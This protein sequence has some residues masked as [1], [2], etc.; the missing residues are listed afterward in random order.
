M[1]NIAMTFDWLSYGAGILTVPAVILVG[2]L[3]IAGYKW[4]KRGINILSDKVNPP[5]AD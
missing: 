2:I 3:S 4:T 5:D 1:V